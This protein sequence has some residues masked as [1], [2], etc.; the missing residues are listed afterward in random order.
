MCALA[1]VPMGGEWAL[2]SDTAAVV[3]VVSAGDV[4]ELLADSRRSVELTTRE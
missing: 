4:A 3:A 2:P 1:P